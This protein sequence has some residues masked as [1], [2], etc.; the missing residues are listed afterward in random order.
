[1]SKQEQQQAAMAKLFDN[2]TVPSSSPSQESQATDNTPPVQQQ[3][4]P[5]QRPKKY[6]EENERVCTIINVELMNKARY[7]AGKEGIALRD[8]FEIGLRFA[9]N[10]Y[11]SSKGPI[12]V[13]KTKPKKGDASKVF[14]I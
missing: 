1:M 13:R 12:H 11:E 3:S 10:D 8:I 4:Q 14:N 7:I 2:L 9:I 6:D 5:S